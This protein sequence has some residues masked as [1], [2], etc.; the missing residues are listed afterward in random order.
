MEYGLFIY[1]LN[2][3]YF[4]LALPTTSKFQDRLYM[5]KRPKL[6]IQNL[7][8][9]DFPG[10]SVDKNLPANVG[11]MSLIPSPGR[12]HMPWRTKPYVPQPLGPTHPRA[13]QVTTTE[14]NLNK[15]N[16]HNEK[17]AHGSREQPSLALESLC[18][19]ANT[20]YNQK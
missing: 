4:I 17:P 8:L 9:Q 16:H 6:C 18:T 1:L 10:G 15:R 2:Y 12:F 5:K 19:A 20:K 14:S 7:W 11:D 3:C 13:L